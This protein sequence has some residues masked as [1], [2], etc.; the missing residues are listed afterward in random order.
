MARYEAVIGLEVH[1]QLRTESKMFC[2]CSAAFGGEPNTHICPVCLGLPGALPVVNARAVSFAVRLGLATGCAIAPE[3]IFARKNYFYPDCP[4]DYQISQFDTPL[5]RNGAMKLDNGKVIRIHRIH[6]EEDAGK[7]LHVEGADHSL[8]DMNRSGVPLVEIVSEPDMRT[9]AEASEYL[10]KLRTLVRYLGIC[11]GNMEEGSLRCDVNLSVR[12][13]G[14]EQLGVKT[15]VKNLNSF[16]QVEQAVE[17]EFE[18][19]SRVLGEGGRITQDT[20]L[21]DP[22]SGRASVMRSKEEAHDYRYFPEPDLRVLRVTAAQMDAI[23]GDMPELPDA[24]RARFVTHYG[25]PAYD[26][27]VLTASREMADYFEAVVTAGADAKAAS[28]WVMGEV[29]RELNER[30]VA[31]DAFPLR[32][33]TLAGLVAL[34]TGGKVSSSAAKTVFAALLDAAA[35]G[36]VTTAGA[37]VQKLGLEQVSDN[38]AI[39]T[40]A[41]AVLDENPDEVARYLGGKEQLLQFFV[42]QLMKRTRGKANPQMATDL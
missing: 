2:G 18:R 35:A 10:Q 34:Q 1:A 38:A 11:D 29:S 33:Q 8:V 36:R 41:T 37:L 28:N 26:A 21:W 9:A 4:K 14:D 22:A 7:L 31:I 13:A 40:E 5:C 17:F 20:L 6:V 23:R 24:K 3:S 19:Q 42:G 39:E 25:I 30:A 32:P 16:K 27:G 12:A 15:E